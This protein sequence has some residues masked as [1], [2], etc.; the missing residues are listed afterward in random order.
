MEPV[1]TS[2]NTISGEYDGKVK[3]EWTSPDS[4]YETITAYDIEFFDSTMTTAT[5][6]L[7]NCDGSLA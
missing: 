6:D 2:L 1:V 7:V 5:P 3:L 4:N